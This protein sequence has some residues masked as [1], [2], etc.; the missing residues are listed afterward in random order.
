MQI[1]AFVGASGTGK[2]YRAITVARKNKIDAIID[3]GLLISENNVIAGKS[4]KCE[5]AKSN[6]PFTVGMYFSNS[7]SS[8]VSIL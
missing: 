7:R 8:G 5:T 2:S 4:A 3:D 1:I 6:K